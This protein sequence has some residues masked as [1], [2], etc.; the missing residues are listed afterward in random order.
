MSLIS[1]TKYETKAFCRRGLQSS[2]VVPHRGKSDRSLR[3][4]LTWHPQSGSAGPPLASLFIQYRM[5]ALHTVQPT[6]MADL[7]SSVNLVKMAPHRHGQG[8]VLQVSLDPAKLAISVYHICLTE[9]APVSLPHRREGL[10]V[11]VVTICSC[12]Q[13]CSFSSQSMAAQ[14][15]GPGSG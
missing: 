6:V 3:Q 4:L 11:S 15:L 9:S 5:P 2:G 10:R 12:I 7:L 8:L 14:L 13:E 1:T